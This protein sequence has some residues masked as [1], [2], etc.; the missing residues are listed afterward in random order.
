MPFLSLLVAVS[1]CLACNTSAIPG[2][3][4]T[5]METNGVPAQVIEPIKNEAS[6]DLNVLQ[7]AA[8]RPAFAKAG[9]SDVCGKSAE[10]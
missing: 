5:A 8:V 6:G 4:L 2:A 3:C 1:L 7:P 10:Q 9:V